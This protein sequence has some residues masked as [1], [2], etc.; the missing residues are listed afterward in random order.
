MQV[1]EMPSDVSPLLLNILEIDTLSSI[2]SQQKTSTRGGTEPTQAKAQ[3]A[4]TWAFSK[5]S[6]KDFSEKPLKA[7][8]SKC[9]SLH[10]C[11]ETC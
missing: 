4:L 9:I 6:Q 1:Y 8:V 10:P 7:R 5:T 11:K 2:S 3:D